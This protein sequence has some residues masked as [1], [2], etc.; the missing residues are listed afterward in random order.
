MPV[1]PR[2]L[3]DKLRDRLAAR[4]AELEKSRRSDLEMIEDLKKDVEEAETLLHELRTLFKIKGASKSGG[5]RNGSTERGAVPTAIRE[6]LG[7]SPSGLTSS[8]I[9]DELVNAGVTD[10]RSLIHSTLF[11]FRKHGKLRFEEKTGKFFAVN[12]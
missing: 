8:E 5:T 4:I 10:K 9:A 6:L 3:A 11:N 7:R 12:G 1:A 2:S